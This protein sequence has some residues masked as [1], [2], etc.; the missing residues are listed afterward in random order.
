M[1]EKGV[2]RLSLRLNLQNEQHSRV[3]RV[4]SSLNRDIH[5]SENQF[6]I[7]AVDFYISSFDSDEILK[8]AAAGKPQYITADDL[9]EIRREM[10]SSLKDEL[11]RLLGSAITGSPASGRREIRADTVME[12]NIGE[13]NPFAAEAANRWG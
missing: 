8:P 3:Y 2:A 12:E 11:I 9:E 4:L 7:N 13:V 1:A 6:I 10:E 5:K